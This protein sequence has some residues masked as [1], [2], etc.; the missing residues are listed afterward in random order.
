M[1]LPFW[2]RSRQT[3]TSDATV[4]TPLSHPQQVD[5]ALD[6]GDEP[7][8]EPAAAEAANANEVRVTL[9]VEQVERAAHDLTFLADV[10]GLDSND[11]RLPAFQQQLRQA[12]EQESA[13]QSKADGQQS[14]IA[15]TLLEWLNTRPRRK[16]RQFLEAHVELLSPESDEILQALIEQYDGRP[17]QQYLRDMQ[18]LLRDAH[19][20]R[21]NVS[22]IAAMREA[23]VN[24]Y[25][26]LVL[27][28]PEW[29][30]QV[31]QQ[32]AEIEA[33]GRPDQTASARI[34]LLR[35]AVSRAQSDEA[36]S[37]ETLA[38]LHALLWDALDDDASI[39]QRQMQEEGI[40]SLQD[41]LGIY[42]IERYAIQYATAQNN[43][44]T[45]YRSRIAGERR[46]NLEEAIR[47]YQE[48]LRVRTLDA[49]PVD[50]HSTLLNR[51]LTE[52]DQEDW[53]A[54]AETYTQAL[55][56]ED[57]LVS[58]A[59][60]IA[61]QD[62]V[63]RDGQSAA[64]RGAF[65]LARLQRLEEAAVLVEHG[66]A[67]GMVTALALDLA[68]P[69][70]IG[71][72]QRRAQY[73]EA[74]EALQQ[75]QQFLNAP[76]VLDIDPE[77]LPSDPAVRR[78]ML[79]N[80]QR[81]VYLEREADFQR[82]KIHYDAVVTEIR[83]AGDP[84]DFLQPA[85][86]ELTILRAAGRGGQGHALVYLLATPWGGLA[87][88]ALDANPD[89]STAARF[90]ALE[91]PLL[92][93][94]LV[95]GLIETQEQGE[96]HRVLSGFAWAQEDAGFGRLLYDWSGETLRAT[97]TTLYQANMAAG[98][99]GAFALAMQ[100]LL[101]IP[102]CAAFADVPLEVLRED[103]PERRQQWAMLENSFNHILMRLEVK[104]CLTQLSDAALRKLVGWLRE[105]GAT[106]VTLIPCGALAAFPLLAAEVAPGKTFAESLPASVAPSARALIQ[107]TEAQTQTDRATSRAGVY[108]VG[109]P[110]PTHQE[111]I[112]GEAEAL[113]IAKLARLLG[114]PGEAKVQEKA[115]RGWLIE[116]L[117]AGLVVDASC[118]G[119][120]DSRSPLDSALLLANG[121]R[122][123]LRDMLSHA[124]ELRGLRL[125]ILSAC[126]T[127][128]LDLRGARDEVRSLAAGM[129][130]AGAQA[131]LAALWSVDDRATYLLM[132]RF[133]QIWLPQMKTMPPAEALALAQ[134]WLRTCTWA[135]LAAWHAD[136]TIIPTEEERREAGASPDYAEEAF[137]TEHAGDP[138]GATKGQPRA[139]RGRG[140]RVDSEDANDMIREWGQRHLEP[141]E[142]AH[143]FADP[144]Y[145]AAFQIT[146]W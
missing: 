130:Q 73:V 111:L 87:L 116:K 139:T 21:D 31:K 38:E 43:L 18:R 114:M 4:G 3:H 74:R 97:A 107:I 120:F 85:L 100:A 48:A 115:R 69:A 137:D 145:W 41:T 121:E 62:A 22:A 110:R 88:A 117:Q 99:S 138:V 29:L 70:Q 63:L 32:L 55:D 123:T 49:F 125:L 47:C 105:E 19:Q 133:A 95:N 37:P 40:S 82:A 33:A 23:Y 52:A 127:A 12:V 1:R 45:A 129:Y 35:A 75:A 86:D 11:E 135:D 104:R 39:Y 94:D 64:T 78:Q 5:A 134:Q 71:N 44:G 42:R 67:R 93:D 51:A 13:T 122:L 24:A 20:R 77:S 84:A 58:L 136:A 54:M 25:G 66:R 101:T 30:E 80:A 6:A 98:Q 15:A 9:T 8:Q 113:T 103:T 141:D 79:D 96:S 143:P 68:N 27:D 83:A 50:Y 61:G 131:V 126:Q 59:G 89:L 142:H 109:D 144:I 14:V 17:E 92:T 28:V 65:A 132:V 53:A 106:G 56:A 108:A 91:L 90:A 81:E 72:L 60:S 124:V 2:R 102:D 46:A 26:G 112:W 7:E 119:S 57:F 140:T 34:N 76:I 118:H 146:G 16:Q 36:L 128:I 10:L